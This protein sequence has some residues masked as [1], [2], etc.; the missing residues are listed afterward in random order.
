MVMGTGVL[1]RERRPL[2]QNASSKRSTT[3]LQASG[4]VALVVLALMALAR[5]VAGL[6]VVVLVDVVVVVL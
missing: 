4:A 6:A 5:A 1:H 3:A 2:K